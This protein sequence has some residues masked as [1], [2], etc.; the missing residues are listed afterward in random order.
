MP[1]RRTSAGNLTKSNSPA[2]AGN[3]YSLR[4]AGIEKRIVRRERLHEIAVIPYEVAQEHLRFLDHHRCQFRREGRIAAPIFGSAEDAV[5][6]QPLAEKLVGGLPSTN[7]LQH[8]PGD[9]F[10]TFGRAQLALC[11]R[12]H[13]RAIRHRVP[14]QIRKPV[15][16]G[17]IAQRT[18]VRAHMKEELRR[19]Q[20]GLDDHTRTFKELSS[21]GGF[22]GEQLVVAAHFDT[23]QWSAERLLA[24]S[25]H[26]LIAALRV[27]IRRRST[28]YGRALARPAVALRRRGRRWLTG[29]E[30]VHITGAKRVEGDPFGRPAVGIFEHRRNA[31]RPRLVLETA[32]EI[33]RWKPIGGPAVVPN[34]IAHGIVVLTVRQTPEP[35]VAGHGRLYDVQPRAGSDHLGVGYRRQMLHPGA[36]HLFFG[37]PRH[38]LHATNMALAIGRLVEQQRTVGIGA[39]NQ[40]CERQAERLDLFCASGVGRK[41]KSCARC[42]SFV[43]VAAAAI[44]LLQHGI[45]RFRKRWRR[46]LSHHNRPCELPRD[47]GR[48]HERENRE[49][50]DRRPVRFHSVYAPRAL[51]DP[52]SG[53]RGSALISR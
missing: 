42:H 49:N 16:N 8:R 25:A 47:F 4:E 53:S 23:G 19:L 43:T 18:A 3:P 11:R 15:G 36:K 6:S 41:M 38:D 26:E 14:E 13:Q 21:L 45:Q 22:C 48:R 33:F 46:C 35:R 51:V 50:N 27:P 7:V 40:A 32:N 24:E 34:Q 39:I 10:D 44:C 52:T 17:V 5:E 30:V 29:H 28:R 31:L 20:H 9:A 12:V 37:R 1:A 2:G